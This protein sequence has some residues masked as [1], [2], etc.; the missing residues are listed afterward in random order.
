M[1]DAT[2]FANYFRLQDTER[3]SF[4]LDPSKDAR[5]YIDLDGYLRRAG[6]FLAEV[7]APTAVWVGGSGS[8]KS[9]LLHAIR[10]TYGETRE[11]DQVYLE[12]SGFGKKSDYK[13]L[14]RQ[15]IQAILNLSGFKKI[16]PE[17]IAEF[18]P[19]LPELS[20]KPDTSLALQNILTGWRKEACNNALAWL[21]GDKTFTG[22]NARKSG[23]SGLFFE[24]H[25]PGEIVL[26]YRALSLLLSKH[27]GK[28]L[29]LLIDEGESFTRVLDV[30][31]IA[32]L[33]AVFRSIFDSTNKELGVFLGLFPSSRQNHPLLRYDVQRRVSDRNRW[34]ELAGL[35]N[36]VRIRDFMRGLWDKLSTHNSPVFQLSPESLVLIEQNLSQLLRTITVGTIETPTPADLLR[37]LTVIGEAAIETHTEP[38]IKGDIL[39]KWLSLG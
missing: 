15:I 1:A 17:Q 31:A 3:V 22:S 8:G 33:G 20:F 26:L 25:E 7:E 16:K 10:S 30:D 19:S 2:Q 24:Q 11:F 27:T 35:G 34:I 14:H 18:K 36:S 4:R 39:K 32:S 12:L 29:L 21:R 38:P 28:R 6:Q 9:H 23:Y 37:L 5:L 13:D